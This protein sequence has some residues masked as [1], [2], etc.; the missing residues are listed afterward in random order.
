[1]SPAEGDA[2][3]PRA[4]DFDACA[5]D[6]GG[7]LL[8]VSYEKR[9][10]SKAYVPSRSLY[11]DMGM[12]SAYTESQFTSKLLDLGSEFGVRTL[13]QIRAVLLHVVPAGSLEV[14][15]VVDIEKDVFYVDADDVTFGRPPPKPKPAKPAG[16]APAPG[17]GA[18]DSGVIDW[19]E[20]DPT[21]PDH[22][23]DADDPD[24]VEVDAILADADKC[25]DSD[26]DAGLHWCCSSC[27][28][29]GHMHYTHVRYDVTLHAITIMLSTAC[30]HLHFS[31]F[32]FA[33]LFTGSD[34]SNG[35]ELGMP[36]VSVLDIPA[37]QRQ[38]KDICVWAKGINSLAVLLP[39]LAEAGHDVV[40]NN[41]NW[42]CTVSGEHLC[43]SWPV[44]GDLFQCHCTG[45]TV[46]TDRCRLHLDRSGLNTDGL[47][48]LK[49][50]AVKWALAGLHGTCA[51]HQLLAREVERARFK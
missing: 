45:H 40:W 2:S 47:D 43:T 20:P 9:F 5:E 51:D 6:V 4:E 18:D 10:A 12:M 16:A 35:A 1:M 8:Q 14:L 37:D 33:N 38:L 13:R 39:L 49:C 3:S 25:D 30:A 32:T 15:E 34:D 21:A 26:S 50:L 41:L 44:G 17:V 36:R 19:F 27:G 28:V 29:N 46:G 11:S 31:C 48:G 24:I 42:N 23:S 22:D 7:M